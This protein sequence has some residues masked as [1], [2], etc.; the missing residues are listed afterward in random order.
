MAATFAM[1]MLDHSTG[2]WLLFDDD[3][4]AD[5]MRALADSL[6]DDWLACDIELYGIV[7]FLR[8]AGSQRVWPVEDDDIHEGT[9]HQLLHAI[10]EEVRFFL[11]NGEYFVHLFFIILGDRLRVEVVEDHDEVSAD[12][13]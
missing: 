4:K 13:Q 12:S 7:Q 5:D 6:L 2:D 9:D 3:R 11:A 1:Y 8:T 10:A